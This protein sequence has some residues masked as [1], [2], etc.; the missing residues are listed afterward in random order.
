MWRCLVLASVLA[1]I[2][3][4]PVETLKSVGALPAHLAGSIEEITACEQGPD[5]E[6]YI[7]DRRLHS[8]FAASPGAN[9]IR[10]IIQIG[11]EPGRVL[12]PTAFDLADD[13]TFVVADA[14]G[15]RGRVQ[16]FYR[17]G[18]SLG[19]FWLPVRDAPLIVLEGSVLSGVGTLEYT[20]KSVFI[21]QPENGAL[22]TEYSL[23]GR[24]LRTF[25]TLRLTGQESDPEV[26]R[27]LNVGA[28]VVNPKGG[29]YY[30]FLAGVPMFRKYDDAG[31]LLFERHVEGPELD[32]YVQSI[33]TTW[34][35]KNVDGRVLPVVEPAIRAAGAD[36]MGNLWLSLRV[37]YT[38]VYDSDG[39]KRRTVQFKAAGTVMPT[40][41]TFT[42]KDQLLVAPGCFLFEA[43]VRS[44]VEP[45][46][47]ASAAR[48]RAALG[49]T[50]YSQRSASRISPSVLTRIGRSN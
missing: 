10:T 27:A 12:R 39:E 3:A 31:K 11:A 18:A 17:S 9:A 48:K 30:V 37:P 20:G 25:G 26:H 28:I 4:V 23:D 13:E 14:P 32:S 44:G 41:L 35:R 36:H 45:A 2:A 6:F 33:P 43:N 15:N 50:E 40:S 29:F 47:G 5:G 24:P 8:V 1:P 16:V 7:F 34:R 46:N 38:Y 19:G 49:I 22:V 21:S 42:K